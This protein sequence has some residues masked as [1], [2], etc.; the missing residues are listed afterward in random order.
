MDT[1][2]DV[3]SSP[4]LEEAEINTDEEMQPTPSSA[5]TQPSNSNQSSDSTPGKIQNQSQVANSDQTKK[6][7]ETNIQKNLQKDFP[8]LPGHATPGYLHETPAEVQLSTISQNEPSSSLTDTLEN[9]RNPQVKEI[10]EL[11]DQ[12]I[13]IATSNLSK[14]QKMRAIF[15]IADEDPGI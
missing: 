9:L 8:P 3:A 12:V 1:N 2:N 15:K 5:S 13:A 4:F 6:I 7:K 10:F 14:H 11:L